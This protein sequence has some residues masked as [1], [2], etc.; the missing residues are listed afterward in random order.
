MPDKHKD[1]K[2]KGELGTYLLGLTLAFVYLRVMHVIDWS[3]GWVL[4]PLWVLVALWVIFGVAII[5]TVIRMR[6]KKLK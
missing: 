5:V 3:W 4:T 6:H 2:A 1:S